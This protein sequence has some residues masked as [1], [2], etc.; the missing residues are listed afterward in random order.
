MRASKPQKEESPFIRDRRQE[1]ATIL[2]LHGWKRVEHIWIYYR[3]RIFVIIFT[4]IVVVSFAHMLWEG[5]KPCRLRVCAV[6]ESGISCED[7][8]DDFYNELKTDGKSGALS[9]N[10]DQP[11]DRDNSYIEVMEMEIMALVSSGRMDVAV[12][13]ED[14]YSYLLSINACMDMGKVW[15]DDKTTR[16]LF[17][18]GEAGATPET[19]GVTGKYAVDITNT[20]FAEK[21]N[22]GEEGGKLYAV[23]ISNTEHFEDAKKLVAALSN[24]A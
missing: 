18:E 11:F 12:C 7:W 2:E 16:F 23:I 5:Q 6:L 15:S 13:G 21:Y 3:T 24:R 10:E 19:P 22:Y 1:L 17:A 8:F 14:L 9:L 4:A 20:P